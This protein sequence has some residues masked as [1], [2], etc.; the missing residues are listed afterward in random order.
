MIIL[1]GVLVERA[2]LISTWRISETKEKLL[3]ESRH[4]DVN[5]LETENDSCCIPELHLGTER[6]ESKREDRLLTVKAADA[7]ITISCTAE[8]VN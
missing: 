5:N 7:F 2:S 8:S 1:N 4:V 6:T 3:L